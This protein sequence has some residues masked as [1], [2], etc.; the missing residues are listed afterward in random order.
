MAQL[1]QKT[2]YTAAFTAAY[3]Y[4]VTATS[5]TRTTG[6]AAALVVTAI[7]VPLHCVRGGR[8]RLLPE[9]L[10]AAEYAGHGPR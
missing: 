7:D 3:A 6:R 4:T 8:P 2:T 9:T 10:A 1:S 5:S